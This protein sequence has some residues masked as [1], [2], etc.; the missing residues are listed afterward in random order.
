V[1]VKLNIEETQRVLAAL[2]KSEDLDLIKR[3]KWS[4]KGLL[5]HGEKA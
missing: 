4:L 2:E 5:R 3:F 1:A